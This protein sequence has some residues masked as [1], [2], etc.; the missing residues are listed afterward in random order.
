MLGLGAGI[1][2]F[3]GV[4]WR[5]GDSPPLA[6]SSSR[7]KSAVR[8][9]SK[10]ARFGRDRLE[11]GSDSA[12]TW[13]SGW[14]KLAQDWLEFGSK[15]ARKT[16]FSAFQAKFK[17]NSSQTQANFKPISSQFRANRSQSKSQIRAKFKPN[18]MSLQAKSKPNSSQPFFPRKFAGVEW[19]ERRGQAG[20]V[21]KRRPLARWESHNHGHGPSTNFSESCTSA[22]CRE[23]CPP[24]VPGTS[25]FLR[26]TLARVL[27]KIGIC[28]AVCRQTQ[29]RRL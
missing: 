14:S 4:A 7:G 5:G 19:L 10:M 21:C 13:L 29:A 23:G 22:F 16:S 28:Q 8:F 1:L 26:C 24:S 2:N 17:P 15:L 25:A 11:F 9:G 18:S 3:E 27:S 20:N 6:E 12:R